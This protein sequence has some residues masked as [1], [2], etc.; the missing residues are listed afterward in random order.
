[1]LPSSRPRESIKSR[2][3]PYGLAIV[4]GASL[5]FVGQ[6]GLLKA[7]PERNRALVIRPLA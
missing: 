3:I 6:M 7:K 5:V 4:A 2:Q 1:L